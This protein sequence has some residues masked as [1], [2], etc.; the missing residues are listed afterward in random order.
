VAVPGWSRV[1]LKMTFLEGM[2]GFSDCAVRENGRR[3]TMRAR[4][5]M[6]V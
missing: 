2:A 3:A 5:F 4:F 6:G 1:A